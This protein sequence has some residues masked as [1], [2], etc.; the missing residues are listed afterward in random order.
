M[1]KSGLLNPKRIKLE[2]KWGYLRFE[3]ETQVLKVKTLIFL[4]AKADFEEMQMQYLNIV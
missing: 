4:Y 1:F 3:I 2:I